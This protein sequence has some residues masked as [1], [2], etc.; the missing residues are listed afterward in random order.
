MRCKTTEPQRRRSYYIFD[1]LVLSGQ[2]LRREPRQNDACSLE[3]KVLP[4]LP[5][6]VQYSAPLDAELGD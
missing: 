2:E 6:L 4:K 3:K 5:E 1:L